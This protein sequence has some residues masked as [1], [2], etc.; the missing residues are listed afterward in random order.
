MNGKNS[1][2]L[3]ALVLA[4]INGGQLLAE[5]LMTSLQTGQQ[6]PDPINPG[7]SASYTISLTKTNSSS[8]TVNLSALGLPSGATASFSPNPVNFAS[9]AT[10]GTATLVISTTSAIRPGYYPFRVVAQDGGSHNTITNTVILD[11]GLLSPGL[12]QMG[13]GCWCFAFATQPGQSYSVQATT[14]L[15]A[16]SWTTLCTTNSGTNNLLVFMDE[17]KAYYPSRFYRAVGQ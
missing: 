2:S 8:M 11:V 16:P 6:A 10:S 1:V 15:C 9:K 4:L 14:N 3:W 17:D 13:D 12:V 7:S 5:P